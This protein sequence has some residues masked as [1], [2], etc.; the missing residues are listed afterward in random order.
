MFQDFFGHP[1]TYIVNI[2]FSN[3]QGILIQITWLKCNEAAERNGRFKVRRESCIGIRQSET[4]VD[5]DWNVWCISCFS[6]ECE[7]GCVGVCE[8]EVL[9][10]S[11]HVISHSLIASR[12]RTSVSAPLKLSLS[13]PITAQLST[14]QS[15]SC[16]TE[17]SFRSLLLPFVESV[18][19]ED[20]TPIL[21]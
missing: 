2:R 14:Q 1:T 10:T 15:N 3:D 12:C 13:Q 19:L 20:R 9:S 8:C 7:C 4:D 17:S 5:G 21:R 6:I 16:S 11:N 18:R